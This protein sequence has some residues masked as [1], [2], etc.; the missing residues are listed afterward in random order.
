MGSLSID[1][2]NSHHMQGP[3]QGLCTKGRIL[4][5]VTVTLVNSNDVDHQASGR[6]ITSPNVGRPPFLIKAFGQF[7]GT[8]VSFICVHIFRYQVF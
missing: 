8:V 5:E 4:S 3:S 2:C 7:Q 1:V 6:K